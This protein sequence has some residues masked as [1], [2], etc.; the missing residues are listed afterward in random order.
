MIMH[1]KYLVLQEHRP[2][3]CT[4]FMR[5]EVNGKE[6]S[7]AHGTF[8]NNIS[9]L[10]K[11]GLFEIAYRSNIAFYTLRGVKFGKAS[12]IAV[13]GNHTGVPYSSASVS[14]VSTSS[15]LSSNPIYRSIKDLPLDKRSVHDLHLRFASP[16][17]YATVN[18]SISDKSAGLDCTVNSKSLDI[19]L[20]VWKIRDLLVKVRIH[21][22]DTVSIV[23]GC[24]LNPI[25]LDVSGIIRLT[26]TLSIVE[27]R[28]S[29]LAKKA[30]PL[31]D[32][33]TAHKD[34]FPN[35]RRTCFSMIPL[36]SQWIVTMWHF[37]TDALTEYSGEKFC[38][39][40]E[41]AEN[42]LIRAY[43]KVMSDNKTRIRLERQEYP[44]ASIADVIEEKL[45]YNRR[46]S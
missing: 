25:A 37:G 16:Q 2:F 13:T 4:D 28:L 18:S 10:I 26:N 5:F 29:R 11:E 20:P 39:T 40:W 35:Y 34:D 22:T 42:V 46:F 17:I 1:M 12:R 45:A 27:E 30:C 3:S 23:I 7:I 33:I 14:S 9:C 19:L 38:M 6:Y 44:N 15:S 32:S 21:R 8:R 41:T 24:S 36:Y 31:G 43:S